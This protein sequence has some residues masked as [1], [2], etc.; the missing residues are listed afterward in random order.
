ME[1]LTP[2]AS[3]ERG[4]FAAALAE[5]LRR[6]SRC[7]KE[8]GGGLANTPTHTNT[9]VRGNTA[10]GHEAAAQVLWTV[11]G[12]VAGR[13]ARNRGR[14]MARGQEVQGIQASVARL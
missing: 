11:K 1:R 4:A 13:V 9:Y 12:G 8:V 7:E 6:N 5:R 3:G 14:H 2:Q 10:R